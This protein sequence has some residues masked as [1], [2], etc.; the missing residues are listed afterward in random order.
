MRTTWTFHSAGQLL[1]GFGAAGQLGDIAL[2]LGAKRVFIVTDPVLVKTG[3]AEYIRSPLQ[4][5]RIAVEIFSGGEP[6]PSFRAAESCIENAR[7]FRPDLLLGLG[8][9]SNMDL[10]K[11]TAT[12]LAHGGTA[13][14]LCRRRKGFRTHFAADLRADHGRHRLGSLGCGGPYRHATTK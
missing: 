5:N 11:V 13:A 7:Q 1:F 2:R 12:V 14:R 3:L 8:G 6:E 9:G 10:A 4:A